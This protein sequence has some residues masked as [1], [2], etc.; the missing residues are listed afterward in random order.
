[1][2]L[3]F[4]F[5]CVVCEYNNKECT[6]YYLVH[7]Y[8]HLNIVIVTKTKFKLALTLRGIFSARVSPMRVLEIAVIKKITIVRVA[9]TAHVGIAQGWN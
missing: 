5:L 3:H 6:I 7:T 4:A 9:V 1:M 2:I 8:V